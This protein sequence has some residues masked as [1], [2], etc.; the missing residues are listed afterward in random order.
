MNQQDI[1]NIIKCSVHIIINKKE[2]A[3]I[4]EYGLLFRSTEDQSLE[5]LQ[6]L[7]FIK[8]ETT[9]KILRT[10]KYVV[11]MLHFTI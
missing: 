3:K 9:S 8:K 4:E 10:F 1:N 2:N 6:F 11:E 5:L 7:Y